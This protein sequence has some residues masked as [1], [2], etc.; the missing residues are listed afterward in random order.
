MAHSLMKRGPPDIL[1]VFLGVLVV[2]QILKPS[3]HAG[4]KALC[5]RLRFRQ[6]A[7]KHA[8]FGAFCFS[9]AFE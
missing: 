1:G 5:E 9:L 6:I 2:V 8:P 7:S 3:I 4:S